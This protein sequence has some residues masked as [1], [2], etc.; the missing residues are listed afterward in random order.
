MTRRGQCGWGLSTSLLTTFLV[1]WPGLA[2]AQTTHTVE[3][4]AIQ[5]IPRDRTVRVGDTVHWVWITGFHNVESGVVNASGDG[6]FDGWFRSGDPIGEVGTTFD[7]RFDQAFFDA[8]PTAGRFFPY[9]CVV[10]AFIGMVGTITV[11]DCLSNDHC[12]DSNPCTDDRCDAGVCVR[13]DNTASCDDL[14][15]CTATD[16][17]TNGTCAG[18][19]V[20]GC[21]RSHSECGDGNACTSDFCENGVC[22]STSGPADPCNDGNPCT[23]ADTCRSGLCVGTPLEVCCA[24]DAECDDE[25]VCTDDRCEVGA[26]RH[27]P[28]AAPCDDGDSCT[29]DDTCAAGDCGG[30]PIPGCCIALSDCASPPCAEA[31][32]VNQRCLD[33]P[34]EGCVTCDADADCE[35]DDPCTDDECAAGACRH[36]FGVAECD[37]GNDCTVGDACVV[38][39]CM[40][41]MVVGCCTVNE[42]CEDDDPC[43]EDSCVESNCVHAP[44][45]GCDPADG[46]DHPDG[47]GT[48]PPAEEPTPRETVVPRV[49]GFV[50]VLPTALALAF[51]GRRDR[52]RRCGGALIA[53]AEPSDK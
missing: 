50:P 27:T 21:C 2:A 24:A 10:H 16:V 23:T 48:E 52:R 11:V 19:P 4:H 30:D 38:G 3:L 33:S 28:N 45:D 31:R 42:D 12:A 43:S 32:C 40:G 51:L 46:H 15:G 5:F 49:C 35:D 17:C 41:A 13:T 1:L 6:V 37:D 39:N 36:G 44:V 8:N 47:E 18:T 34:L 7:F 22:R 25:D 14:D 29:R 9:Y 53:T 20:A 26:C